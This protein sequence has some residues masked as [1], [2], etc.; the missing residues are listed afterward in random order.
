MMKRKL[1]ITV[2]ILIT[3]ASLGAAVFF[4]NQAKHQQQ[5]PPGT[6]T[7][8]PGGSGTSDGGDPASSTGGASGGSEGGE[9]SGP[10]TSPAQ[11]PLQ[12]QIEQ[13]YTARLQSTGSSYESRLNSL[14]ASAAG[15]Y[16]AAKKADPNAGIT[17]LTNK[18]Y[19]A[20]QALE[21]ECDAKMYAILDAFENELRA[22]SLPV[23]AAVRARAAYDAAKS[24]RAGQI[25]SA[26]P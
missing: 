26:K 4:Y 17:P 3:A 9:T 16:Q 7:S 14:L 1:L 18:Y 12:A 19:A 20:G 5:S 25:L 6:Q 11:N 24:D 21:A 10:Q 22:N 15:D 23:D 2:L 8:A 13:K